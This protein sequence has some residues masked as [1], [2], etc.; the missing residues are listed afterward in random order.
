MNRVFTSLCVIA[1]FSLPIAGG[2]ASDCAKLCQKQTECWAKGEKT[3]SNQTVVAS[4]R[5]KLCQVW[6]KARAGD[7][8]FGDQMARAFECTSESCSDFSACLN[9]AVQATSTQN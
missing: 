6:C 5:E 7:P 1:A 4:K 2:C 9:R 3:G 8:K